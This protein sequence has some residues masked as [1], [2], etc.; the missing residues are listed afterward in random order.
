ML[1]AVAGASGFVGRHLLESKSGD[2]RIRALSRSPRPSTED[3]EWVV[4]DL[5][6]HQST[7]RALQGVDVAVYL[8]HS[9]LP[10]TR[11]FQ[12][13]FEDTDLLLA[14][15][16]SRACVAAGVKRIIYL[17]GL[18]PEGEM[19]KHLESRLEVEEV[20][21]SSGIPT[22]VLRAGMVVGDGGSSFEVLKNLVLN[23]PAMIL[24]H[25]T[26]STTQAVYIDDLVRVL[27]ACIESHR[28]TG[29]TIDVVNGEQFTYEDL[30]RQ[31]A[32]HFGRRT[33][34]F[35]VPVNYLGLSKL[36]VTIFGES[37]YELVSPLVDSLQCDLPAPEVPEEISDLIHYRS[38]ADMLEN[39]SKEKSRKGSRRKSSGENR[40]RSIQRLAENPLSE[41]E[42]SRE[43]FHWL[44]ESLNGL[45]RAEREGDLI[46]FFAVGIG[47]P[48][49]VLQLIEEPQNLD[50]AKFHI[51]GGLLTRTGDTGWLEFRSVAGGKYVL[52]SINEFEPSLPW[53]LY[54]LT[55][56]PVHAWVMNRFSR[57][58]A[59]MS[60][61]GEA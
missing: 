31:T 35:S 22:T 32:R 38:Y 12:G 7:L 54:K 20:F 23:L 49:L 39:V 56:A 36:W 2:F 33:V 41:E 37:D 43:Y 57:H 16:F 25:W 13:S 4:A 17:G 1:V 21:A 24:P 47:S 53:Y 42:I 14:D 26:K 9:M 30:I 44:P 59:T 18:V 61:G 8:V 27:N 48:L 3:V 5:F 29:K 55:Q 6:S 52:S 34:F 28:F 46:E 10:S 45:L 60:A 50:R 40:V 58:L 19:S 51:V 15:N 11:L